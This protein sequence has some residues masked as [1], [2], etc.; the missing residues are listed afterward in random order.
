VRTL[1]VVGGLIRDGDRILLA[2]RPPGGS[3][4]GYWEF[5]GGKVESGESPQEALARELHEELG[6]EVAVH[7]LI[8]RVQHPYPA[9]H[10]DF[11]VYECVVLT[12]TPACIGVHALAWPTLRADRD[13]TPEFALPPADIPVLHALRRAA[14][15][16][17]DPPVS[18]QGPG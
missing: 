2:Q 14:G 5:P 7:Q 18:P 16:P 9:F 11:S 8:A 15:I 12:G 4:G 10:I 6:V 1:V 13:D 3:F 17:P